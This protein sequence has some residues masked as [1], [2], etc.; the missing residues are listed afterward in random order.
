MRFYGRRLFQPELLADRV[1]GVELLPAEELDLLL[2]RL[3]ALVNGLHLFIRTV[4]EMAVRGRSLE[5][6][7][8]QTEPLDDLGRAQVEQLRYAARDLAVGEPSLPVPRVSTYT[9]S[10]SAIPIA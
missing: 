1:D 8:T 4:A 7:I 10:G 9:L 6:R 2:H 5:N 3:A